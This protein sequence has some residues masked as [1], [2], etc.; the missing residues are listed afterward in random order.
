MAV[1]VHVSDD[2]VDVTF[3][4]ADKWL[5][6]NPKGQHLAIA[7]ITSA[8]VVPRAEAATDRGW[9]AGGGWFPGALATGWFT[10]KGRKGPRQ[11]WC[12]YRDQEVL[13]IETR[14]ERPCRVVLQHPDRHDLAWYIGERLARR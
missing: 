3:T 1:H 5:S 11:L 13:V 9:R 14:L 12:V 6:L 4:G 10:V 2:A 7:D 8:R